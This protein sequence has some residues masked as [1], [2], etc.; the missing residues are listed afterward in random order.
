MTALQT[1]SLTNKNLATTQNRIATGDKYLDAGKLFVAKFNA[2]GSG[3]WIELSIANSAIAAAV[4]EAASV[5]SAPG[6]D[7]VSSGASPH[8]ASTRART[9]CCPRSAKPSVAR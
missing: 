3:Q 7:V 9:A 5:P 6:V 2:D 1:L 4:G 8:A